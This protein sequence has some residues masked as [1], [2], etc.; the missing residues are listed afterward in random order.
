MNLSHV[1]RRVRRVLR[2]ACTLDAR[3]RRLV[4]RSRANRRRPDADLSQ[5][6][7][8]ALRR[9]PEDNVAQALHVFGIL[10]FPPDTTPIMSVGG[11]P[12]R[13]IS[14][15]NSFAEDATLAEV[16]ARSMVTCR[17]GM[18]SEFPLPANADCSTIYVC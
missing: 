15:G 1:A 10:A 8:H 7:R 14:A 3:N 12:A 4:R 6:G 18:H 5:S 16:R 11:E 13:A 2:R 9:E 17:H